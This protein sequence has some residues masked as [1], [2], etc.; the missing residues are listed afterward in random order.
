M[1]KAEI[2][3]FGKG[4]KNITKV[5]SRAEFE[6]KTDSESIGKRI[7]YVEK[8]FRG[9]KPPKLDLTKQFDE[10]KK[11]KLRFKLPELKKP[12]EMKWPKFRLPRIKFKRPRLRLRDIRLP[13]FK[14]SKIKFKIPKLKLRE[15][16]LPRFKLSRIFSFKKEREELKKREKISIKAVK[17]SEKTLEKILKKDIRK[18]KRFRIRIP[19][20][21]F[22]KHIR[23]VFRRADRSIEKLKPPRINLSKLFRFKK[24]KEIFKKEKELIRKGEKKIGKGIKE[25]SKFGEEIHEEVSRALITAF[26][27]K[28]WKPL[29]KEFE[30]AFAGKKEHKKEHSELLKEL[31]KLKTKLEKGEN[32]AE[33]KLIRLRK[34]ADTIIRDLSVYVKKMHLPREVYELK[35]SLRIKKDILNIKRKM[36]EVDNKVIR[37]LRPEKKKAEDRNG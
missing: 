20:I 29:V 36:K 37:F 26:G 3:V 18:I 10:L 17:K 25:A 32:I 7:F 6:L 4:F 34:K 24:E 23:K 2:K 27:K 15:I 30:K 1:I 33:K 28:T 5:F 13:R 14:L 11:V 8:K 16:K 9:F 31:G 35:R 19:K 21:N 12:K 22:K